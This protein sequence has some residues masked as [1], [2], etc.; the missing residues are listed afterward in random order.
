MLGEGTELAVN[1]PNAW[2]K[3]A[4]GLPPMEDR[5]VVSFLVQNANDA[6]PDE[7]S[8]TEDKHAHTPIRSRHSTGTTLEP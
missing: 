4:L 6:R 8:P 3:I 7:A 1:M 5:Y 2:W